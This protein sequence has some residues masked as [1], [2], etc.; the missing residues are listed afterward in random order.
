MAFNFMIH[1]L[2][3]SLS[4]HDV[5]STPQFSLKR[6]HSTLVTEAVNRFLF[7]GLKWAPVSQQ[8]KIM[9]VLFPTGSLSQM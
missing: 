5:A 1:I 2:P 4:A 6:K 3:L 7:V 8:M 9:W